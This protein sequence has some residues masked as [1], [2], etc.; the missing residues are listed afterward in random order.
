MGTISRAMD[1]IVPQDKLNSEH[2]SPTTG[3]LDAPSS[4][5]SRQKIPIDPGVLPQTKGGHIDY[6]DERLRKIA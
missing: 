2:K 5:V 6:W 1:K 4:Q 3:G